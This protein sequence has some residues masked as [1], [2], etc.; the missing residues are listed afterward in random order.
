MTVSAAAG[1][2]TQVGPAAVPVGGLLVGAG[3]AQRHLVL[4]GLA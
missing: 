1:P 2:P 3:D 4:N